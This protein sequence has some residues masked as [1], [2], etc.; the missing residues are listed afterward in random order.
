ME[1]I[2]NDHDNFIFKKR[3]NS[4]KQSIMAHKSRSRLNKRKHQQSDLTIVEPFPIVVDTTNL[5]HILQKCKICIY[6]NS[7]LSKLKSIAEGLG[8]HVSTELAKTT[9]HLVIEPKGDLRQ[10][11]VVNQA[12]S[13]GIVCA[14]PRWLLACYAERRFC[15]PTAYQYD[16]DENRH[17]LDSSTHDSQGTHSTV[18]NPFNTTYVD[19]DTLEKEK[20]LQGGQ[21]RMDGFVTRTPGENARIEPENPFAGSDTVLPE[22]IVNETVVEETVLEETGNTQQEI[23]EEFFY[24]TSSQPSVEEEAETEEEKEKKRLKSQQRNE[25]MEKALELRRSLLNE[26][27]KI[28]EEISLRK[29]RVVSN[30]YGE[31]LKIWY[32]EQSF[33]QEAIKRRR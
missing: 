10:M 18:Y 22:T 14:S 7:N 23:A 1:P 25:E 9:T 33:H 28:K 17:I 13:K 16:I 11:R 27:N 3:I 15:P 19:F 8:A 12:V 4:N 29:R 24:N 26:K 32:G 5:P 2:R 30:T 31:R 21:L 20:P 6:K